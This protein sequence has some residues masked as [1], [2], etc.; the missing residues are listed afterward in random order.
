MPPKSPENGQY[1]GERTN[2]P[3]DHNYA[4]VP[5]GKIMQVR[6]RYSPRIRKREGPFF[7]R[8]VDGDG[9]CNKQH[10]KGSKLESTTYL[11]RESWQW[12]LSRVS[13]GTEA[14]KQ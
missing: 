13:G 3:L 6:T 2:R 10:N 11:P 12:L 7:A 8:E 5:D 1:S 14:S 4:R 9:R